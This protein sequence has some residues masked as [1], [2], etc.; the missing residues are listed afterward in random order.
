MKAAYIDA[1]APSGNIKVGQVPTPKPRAGEISVAVA[2]AG[3]NPADAKIA[4]GLFQSRLPNH[5]PLILG[6]EASGIVHDLGEGVTSFKKG[7]KVYL[8]CK[9]PT[10]QWGTWAEYVTCAAE[11]VALVPKNISMAEAAAVPLAG[12]TAWQALFDKAQLQSGERILI[13]AGGG[14][15]GG[16]A[17]QWAKTHGA[18]VITTASP[19]KS[20]YV[21]QLGADEII[22]YQKNSFVEQIRRTHPSGIDV[23]FD[24]IGGSVYRQSF[25]V[26]KPGGR[27]VSLL[28][29]PDS[30][31]AQKYHVRAEYFM[32][33]PNGKQLKE[34]AR[35]L[36]LGK[37]KPP[38]VQEMSL[39]E[40]P[41]AIDEIR[42]GHTLGKIVLE[43]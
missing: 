35:L 21:K 42:K 32:V 40:A 15:V 9:K 5:F 39:D 4:E 23:V 2:Y 14:G 7:D 1:F 10:I 29:H 18:Y 20:A 37:A 8:Y 43:I 16:F 13:H 22:D 28:E 12:L 38:V 3:V 19:A 11:H 24:T 26:L 36:E 41:L 27:I 6:W 33:S 34:M 17:I 25:E 30:G 31:L